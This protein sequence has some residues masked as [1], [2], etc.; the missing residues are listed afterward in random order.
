M[1]NVYTQL[2]KISS[3]C[4][5]G[6][7]IE[8]FSPVDGKLIASVES[9]DLAAYNKT[10]EVS[11]KAFDDFAGKETNIDDINNIVKEMGTLEDF[12]EAYTDFET[13][14]SKSEGQESNT[15][16]NKKCLNQ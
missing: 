13:N 8:S 11:K 10:I 1:F 6:S 15:R 7:I 12:K 2:I 16:E 3:T 4:Y 5:R 14:E 9:A